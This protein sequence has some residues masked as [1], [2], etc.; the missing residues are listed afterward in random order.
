[1]RRVRLF[2][3]RDNPPDPAFGLSRPWPCILGFPPPPQAS[4]VSAREEE[5]TYSHAL[6]SHSHQCF[7]RH[8]LINFHASDPPLCPTLTTL[9]GS[10]GLPAGRPQ[11]L[12]MV[13]AI[14]LLS[15]KVEVRVRNTA[16][17][18]RF[19]LRDRY[20]GHVYRDSESRS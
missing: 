7:L 1:M 6:L 8:T 3:S 19:R 14:L 20:C 12:M 16:A 17:Y 2:E 15:S 13:W 18:F 11:L 10:G 5:Y 9:L 4:T